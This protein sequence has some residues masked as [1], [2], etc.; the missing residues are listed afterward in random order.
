MRRK[1]ALIL[2]HISWRWRSMGEHSPSIQN[3]KSYIK[4]R[5]ERLWEGKGEGRRRGRERAGCKIETMNPSS[6]KRKK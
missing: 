6:S 1:A 2:I 4:K 5:K 3:T